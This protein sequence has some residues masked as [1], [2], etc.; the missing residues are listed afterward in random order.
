MTIKIKKLLLVNWILYIYISSGL[1]VKCL[2]L[3]V[4][5]KTKRT[6]HKWKGMVYYELR[7]HIKEKAQEGCH[8]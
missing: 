8:I 3:G 1:L 4:S 5:I 7:V 6:M 2:G